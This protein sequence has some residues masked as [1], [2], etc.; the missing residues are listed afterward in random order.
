MFSAG[1]F[2]VKRSRRSYALRLLFVAAFCFSIAAPLLAEDAAVKADK[3]VYAPNEKITVKFSGFPGNEQD[4]ITI[5]KASDPPS[6]YGQY[7]YLNRKRSGTLDFNGF[8]VGKYEVR[9]FFNWPEGGY[10]IQ[11]RYVFTVQAAE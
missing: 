2:S 5:V 1:P 3:Q 8:P 7:F 10:T 6:S 4:W 11:A 9:G